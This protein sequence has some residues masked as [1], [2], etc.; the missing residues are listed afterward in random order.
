MSQNRGVVPGCPE[1]GSSGGKVP[2]GRLPAVRRAVFDRM[3]SCRKD[4][5][6]NV[7]AAGNSNQS[8][9]LTVDTLPRIYGCRACVGR[10]IFAGGLHPPGAEKSKGYRRI[11]RALQSDGSFNHIAVPNR[12]DLQSD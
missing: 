9:F 7:H 11:V 3:P 12:P 10:A 4:C 8:S 5:A 6:A 2:P 1:P